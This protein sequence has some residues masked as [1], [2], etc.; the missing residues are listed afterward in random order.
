MRQIG[1]LAIRPKFELR[2]KDPHGVRKS[3]VVLCSITQTDHSP[4]RGAQNF[5]FYGSWKFDTSVA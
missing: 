3:L 2:L 5:D 1:E 4:R